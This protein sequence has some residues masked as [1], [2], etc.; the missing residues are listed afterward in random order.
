MR[1]QRATRT[2]AAALA[3]AVTAVLAVAACAQPGTTGTARDVG[4]PQNSAPVNV[5]SPEP[6]GPPPA[7]SPAP[8]PTST[9]TVPPPDSFSGPPPATGGPKGD[10]VLS[11]SVHLGAEPTCLLLDSDKIEYLLLMSGVST[12]RAGQTVVVIGHPAHGIMTHCMQGM[13]FQVDKIVSVTG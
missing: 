8:Q 2:R 11:G 5:A 9:S 1:L 12:M 6:S 10:V 4:A 7:G 13:P 3:A